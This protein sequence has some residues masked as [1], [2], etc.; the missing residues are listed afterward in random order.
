ME[1]L[2]Y[3]ES[4]NKY[5]INVWYLHLALLMLINVGF[6][7]GTAWS[8]VIIVIADLYI[9]SEIFMGYREKK[10]IKKTISHYNEYVEL[11]TF[12]LVKDGLRDEYC[13][14]AKLW[15]LDNYTKLWMP[16][17]IYEDEEQVYKSNKGDVYIA[18]GYLKYTKGYKHKECKA[19]YSIIFKD[20]E[21]YMS[22]IDNLVL[23]N[24]KKRLPEPYTRGDIYNK[25][26]FVSLLPTIFIDIILL[27]TYIRY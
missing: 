25:S 5:A 18:S 10:K 21:H 9:F 17:F 15:I 7:K 16:Q 4:L 6:Y 14:K 11:Y 27:Y 19:K 12:S 8:I 24:Y 26:I 22:N 13:I 23:S 2:E 1:K 20:G 3:K